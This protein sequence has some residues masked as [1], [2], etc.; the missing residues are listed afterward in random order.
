MCVN[1]L[2]RFVPWSP[3]VK[4]EPAIIGLKPGAL[5]CCTLVHLLAVVIDLF[6]LLAKVHL[7]TRLSTG[8]KERCI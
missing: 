4:L 1:K 3:L 5:P 2:F 8:V 7:T 6:T